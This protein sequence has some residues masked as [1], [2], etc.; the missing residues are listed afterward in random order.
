MTQPTSIYATIFAISA[1]KTARRNP[2]VSIFGGVKFKST[3]YSSTDPTT[4]AIASRHGA[5]GGAIFVYAGKF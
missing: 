1:P 3:N 2:S 5:S 4:R